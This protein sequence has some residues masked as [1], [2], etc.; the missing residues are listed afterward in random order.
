[1]TYK[2]K[3]KGKYM[4]AAKNSE[5][6]AREDINNF[7]KIDCQLVPTLNIESRDPCTCNHVFNVKGK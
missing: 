1:M 4:C 7:W 2:R 5:I 6:L 3:T